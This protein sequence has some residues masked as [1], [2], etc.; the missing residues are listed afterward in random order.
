MIRSHEHP[1]LGLTVETGEPAREEA[2]CTRGGRGLVLQWLHPIDTWIS[3]P[4]ESVQAGLPYKCQ[5]FQ[6]L[7]CLITY[8]LVLLDTTA[9]N[10]WEGFLFVLPCWCISSFCRCKVASQG[11]RSHSDPLFLRLLGEAHLSVRFRQHFTI[12]FP[13]DPLGTS[14]GQHA[15]GLWRG[16][17]LRAMSGQGRPSQEPCRGHPH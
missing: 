13:A 14:Q 7:A 1:S 3:S 10:W 12:Y 4:H 8:L 5:V 6:C 17:Q 15:A 9:L 2:A 11:G 16:L